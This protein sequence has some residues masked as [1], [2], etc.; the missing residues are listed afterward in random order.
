MNI[1]FYTTVSMVYK[2]VSMNFT[3]SHKSFDLDKV[4]IPI[5][6][7]LDLSNALDTLD[8]VILLQTLYHYGI[9]S[10]E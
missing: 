2:K 3:K 6:I 10:V 9:T 7:F 5:F 8:H 1:N 4:E